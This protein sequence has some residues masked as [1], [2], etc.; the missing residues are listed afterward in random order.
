MAA[1]SNSTSDGIQVQ[2]RTYSNDTVYTDEWWLAEC[3]HE[4]SISLI[5]QEEFYWCWVASAQMFAKSYYPSMSLLQE[6]AVR[7]VKGNVVNETATLTQTMQ[8]INYFTYAYNNTYLDISCHE[9][10]IYSA[11]NM[12]CILENGDP[13]LIFSYRYSNLSDPSSI[14]SGHAYIIYGYAAING[15]YRFLIHD[16]WPEDIGKTYMIS[17]QKLYSGQRCLD[18]IVLDGD[19]NTRIWHSTIVRNSTYSNDPQPYYLAS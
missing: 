13:I 17:Y 11:E 9:E 18:D 15:G 14:V 6:N 2:Q 8:A 4:L 19:S 7:D 10:E 3:G 16:P 1:A 12:V 5:A